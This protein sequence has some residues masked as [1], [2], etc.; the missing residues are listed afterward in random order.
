MKY[1]DDVVLV[2]ASDDKLVVTKPADC[3]VQ[4]D[5]ETLVTVQQLTDTIRASK[6]LPDLYE[7]LGFKYDQRK[8]S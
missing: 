6:S 1:P 4:P 7:R 8:S 3:W 5:R 2:T